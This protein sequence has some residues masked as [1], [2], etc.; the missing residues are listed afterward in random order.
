MRNTGQSFK[1]GA[2]QSNSPNFANPEILSAGYVR[3]LTYT[4]VFGGRFPLTPG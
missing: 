4:R 3:A 2:A 1:A